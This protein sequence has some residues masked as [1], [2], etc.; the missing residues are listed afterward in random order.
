MLLK[1]NILYLYE[2]GMPLKK[3]YYICLRTGYSLTTPPR[4]SRLET[5][6]RGTFASPQSLATLLTSNPTMLFI[7]VQQ[8]HTTSVSVSYAACWYG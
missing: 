5:H 3:I 8:L 1:K 4:C 2:G 6:P 7:G